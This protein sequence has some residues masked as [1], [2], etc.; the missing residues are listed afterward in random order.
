MN[1]DHKIFYTRGSLENKYNIYSSDGKLLRTVDELY[2]CENGIH[3]NTY[4]INDYSEENL[5]K[6][7][8]F[9]EKI[10]NYLRIIYYMILV[11]LVVN[12]IF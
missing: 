7:R 1:Y 11:I 6:V 5:Y 4:V 12:I 9:D 3:E 8:I 10:M 2:M